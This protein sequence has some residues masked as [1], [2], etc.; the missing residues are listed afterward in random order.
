MQ[1]EVIRKPVYLLVMRDVFDKETNELIRLEAKNL[2]TQ[3]AS[4]TKGVDKSIRNNQ[5]IFMDNLYMPTPEQTL[6]RSQSIL[7][8]AFE[9]L[10]VNTEFSQVLGSSEYPLNHFNLTNYHETQ[11]STYDNG[12]KYLWHIDGMQNK[13][14]CI[15]MVYY[16]F[17]EPKRFEGGEIC[18]TNT[19]I[20]NCKPIKESNFKEEHYIEI[21]PEN[22]MLVVFSSALPHSVKDANAKDQE[23]IRYSAQVWVGLK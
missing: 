20:Y 17:K 4:V 18:F 3:E 22:N 11:I 23:H 10:F 7:L 14:R 21:T 16:F 13:T 1:I 8:N 19:P 6:R 5:V 15:S 9:N 12:E 2:R